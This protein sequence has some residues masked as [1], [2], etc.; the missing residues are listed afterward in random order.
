MKEKF[1]P[2]IVFML[3]LTLLFPSQVFAG[4]EEN[5][6]IEDETGDDV[7]DYLD[8]ISAWFYE[9]AQQQE[10]LFWSPPAFEEATHQLMSF[11]ISIVCLL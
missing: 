3:F 7:I 8:I 2:I 10:Y 6:E 9:D 4:D 5:P 1:F 11:R